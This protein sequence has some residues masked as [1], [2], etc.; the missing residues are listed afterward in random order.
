MDKSVRFLI[1]H[2]LINSSNAS[3]IVRVDFL[4]IVIF[5]IGYTS[6]SV[7]FVIIE[8][9]SEVSNNPT[10]NKKSTTPNRVVLI[11]KVPGSG[12]EPETRGF[13]VLCSTN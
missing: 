13:S 7:C 11:N 10:N 3:L 8:S 6:L 4:D 1:L 5:S 9:L 2:F 12:I